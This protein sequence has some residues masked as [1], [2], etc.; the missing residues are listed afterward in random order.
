MLGYIVRKQQ[1]I[2]V[3]WSLVETETD[4]VVTDPILMLTLD[5]LFAF[6]DVIYEQGEA[7]TQ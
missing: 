4:M 2:K 1:L 5:L 3:L 7:S 6:S